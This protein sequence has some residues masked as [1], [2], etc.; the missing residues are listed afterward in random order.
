[1]SAPLTSQQKRK[2]G[3]AIVA[4]DMREAAVVSGLLNASR[5]TSDICGDGLWETLGEVL[6]QLQQR[7]DASLI[8]AGVN[9]NWMTELAIEKGWSE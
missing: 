4:L 7:V 8:K 9:I 2:R 6:P 3:K 5:K 1:M